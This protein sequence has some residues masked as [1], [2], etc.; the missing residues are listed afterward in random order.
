VGHY[1]LFCH[2]FTE[3]FRKNL[4]SSSQT[5]P[6][7]SRG[8]QDLTVF[9]VKVTLFRGMMPSHDLFTSPIILHDVTY[10]TAW[11]RKI[12]VIPGAVQMFRPGETVVLVFFCSCTV[13]PRTNGLIVGV[14]GPIM[15]IVR[16]FRIIYTRTCMYRH[17]A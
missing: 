3:K 16:Y 1:V 10:H 9:T 8:F 12:L 15:P 2:Q 14:G 4:S 7:S 17:I 13:D 6:V 5:S 11:Q